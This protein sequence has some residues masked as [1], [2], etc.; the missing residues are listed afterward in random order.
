[1]ETAIDVNNLPRRKIQFAFGDC[2]DGFGD[3]FWLS[4]AFNRRYPIGYKFIV[5]FFNDT[6]H[7]GFN[8]AGANFKYAYPEFREPV[9]I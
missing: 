4:P 9:G 2:T 6:C 1:M 8:N 3:V 5:F 7:I